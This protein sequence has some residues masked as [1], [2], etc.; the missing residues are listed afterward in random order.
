MMAAEDEAD[1]NLTLD[2]G[3][4]RRQRDGREHL[5]DLQA[6]RAQVPG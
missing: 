5:R 4:I 3:A 6:R 2:D 1:K